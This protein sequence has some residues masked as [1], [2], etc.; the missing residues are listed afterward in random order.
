MLLILPLSQHPIFI[1]RGSTFPKGRDFISAQFRGGGLFSGNLGKVEIFK[2]F[3]S[4]FLENLT[5]LCA[6]FEKI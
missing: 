3:Y 5:I 2:P 1:L 4:F 6:F